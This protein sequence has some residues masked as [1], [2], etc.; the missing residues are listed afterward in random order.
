MISQIE[1]KLSHIGDKFVIINVSGIGFKVA[2]TKDLLFQFEKEETK[3][4]SLFTYLSVKEDALDLYGFED[5]NDLDFFEKIISVSGIGPKKALGIMS[6]APTQTLK[7][8]IAS[9]DI[10]YLTQVSGI[11][12]KNAEKIVLELKDKMREGEDGDGEFLKEESD[13]IMAIKS[14]GYTANDARKA[15]KNMP[16]ELK[17]LSQRV[18]WAL[19]E[20]GK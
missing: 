5:R 12:A 10:S 8:A 20:L 2:V 9:K 1:G 4:V 6:I 15:I 7:K 14:L 13:I 17:G 18:K 19:K 3:T 11:G 16:T